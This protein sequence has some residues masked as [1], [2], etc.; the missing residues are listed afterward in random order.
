M[1]TRLLNKRNEDFFSSIK[2]GKIWEKATQLKG[3]INKMTQ[4]EK[5]AALFLP[6]FVSR[7]YRAKIAR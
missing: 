2:N 3:D 1:F 5:I 4:G 6:I 7:V